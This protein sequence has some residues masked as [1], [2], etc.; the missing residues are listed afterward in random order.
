M[1]GERLSLPLHPGDDGEHVTFCRICE[2]LCGMVATVRDGRV[3]DMRGDTLNPHS[4]GHHCVKGPAILDLTYDPDRVL[5]PLKR[6]ARPGEFSRVSW[7]EALTEI[8]ARLGAILDQHG[9]DAFAC[10]LGNP[11]AYSWSMWLYSR[12]FLDATGSHK[13]YSAASQDSSSRSLA[14][15]LLYGKPYLLPVPDIVNA[16]FVI[17]FGANPLASKGSILSDPQLRQHLNLVHKRG[18]VVVV[19]PRR[20]ETARI[21]DHVSVRPDTDAYLL[22]ALLSTIVERGWIDRE[23]LDTRTAGAEDFIAAVRSFDVTELSARCDVPIETIRELAEQFATTPRAAAY[24]RVGICRGRFATLTNVLV[25]ALSILTGKFGQR[26]CACFGYSISDAG[27]ALGMKGAGTYHSRIGNLPDVG[28]QMA[29]AMLPHD[30][31]EDGPGQVRAFMTVAGNPVLSAPGSGQLEQAL[32]QLELMF[33][34]DLYVTETNKY[35]DYILPAATFIERED[36]LM[37]RTGFMPEPFIQH[38]DAVVKPLGEARIEHD[39][40]QELARRMSLPWRLGDPR[41]VNDAALRRSDA[42]D[43][44][45]EHPDGLSIDRLRREYPHGRVLEG[46]YPPQDWTGRLPGS[47]HRIRLWSETLT[48]EFDRLRGAPAEPGAQLKLFGRRDPRSHNSWMHNSERLVRRQTPRLLMHPADA[49]ARAIADG[50]LVRV[51]SRSGEVRVQVEVTTEVHPGSVCYPH[52]WGHDAGWTRAN[53]QPSANI[54]V[55]ASIDPADQEQ[56]SGMSFLDGIP[57]DV[58]PVSEEDEV[59]R[60]SPAVGTVA[61]TAP[62]EDVQTM[63]TESIVA[64]PG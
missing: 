43:R 51:V 6:G 9:P 42:G 58:L 11:A 8:A 54:N 23:F 16:D 52:G 1:D 36:M 32:T 14:C 18:R 30:I 20:T 10:Y 63:M 55:I 28:G 59:R 26:G 3:V 21:Y 12:A 64:H 24:S 15:D 40:F 19:D 22:L 35:A 47:D 27:E 56:I 5:Y 50:S 25:D 61:P 33:S 4:R 2:V 37:M 49:T 34:L 46:K 44:G 62:T 31:T 45:G 41:E 7:D 17:M 53:A 60:D 38:T 48:S 13:C 57:V 39:V 29:T